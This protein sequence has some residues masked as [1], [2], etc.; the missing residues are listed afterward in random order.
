MRNR[1]PL[2]SI[3]ALAL[4]VTACSSARK[5]KPER[6]ATEQLLI[7]RAA[8]AAAERLELPIPAGTRIHIVPANF[9]S[10]DGKYAVGAIR[11]QFLRNGAR[12]AKD[13]DG[14]DMIVNIRAGALSIDEKEVLLGTPEIDIS[15][16]TLPSLA[17]YHETER[18]GVAQFVA[19]VT[20]AGNG[21]LIGTTGPQFGYSHKRRLTILF[22]FSTSSDDL[23]PEDQRDD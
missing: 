11:D 12:L 5:T 23:S 20:D 2:V 19:T 3:L 10:P 8:D 18:K 14:A 7:S 1:L 21:R 22:V 16:V 9:D 17:L 13:R 6:T 4:L 15:L